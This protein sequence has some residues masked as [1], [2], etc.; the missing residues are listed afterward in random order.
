VRLDDLVSRARDA[1]RLRAEAE[2]TVATYEAMEGYS[3][4][5]EDEHRSRTL[6]LFA[7]LAHLQETTAT[8]GLGTPFRRTDFFDHY[9]EEGPKSSFTSSRGRTGRRRFFSSANAQHIDAILNRMR[10]WRAEQL[11]SDELEALILSVLLGAVERVSN[12][13]GTYHDFPRDTYD[14]RALRPMRLMPPALDGLLGPPTSHIV[15]N[16]L[17]TLE[18]IQDVPE[19]AVL[20]IDPP[21]NFRQYTAYYFLP[22]IICRYPTLEDLDGYFAGVRYVRGQNPA[23]DFVSSFCK[24]REF[25]PSL[26]TLIQRAN[27]K[28]VI[29]SYFDGRNH[30]NEFKSEC[31]GE[32]FR[33]LQQFF[34]ED[35]VFA[36][37]SLR[38]QPVTRLNYQSYGG[39]KAKNI[40]EYLFVASKN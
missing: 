32:G 4:V 1:R 18:F 12:T 19:H 7:L 10:Y 13:Q 5:T 29:L 22:N 27:T 38:I 25:I 15:G 28:T 24:A 33:R 40:S 9:C 31:N 8:R 39:Y 23:D 14:P 26:R 6:E 35:D 30:W 21:Y 17:D 36:T 37:G 11:M 2:A 34:E 16:A 20:Y 3:Y